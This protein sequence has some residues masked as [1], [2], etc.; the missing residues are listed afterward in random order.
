MPNDPR[1]ENAQQEGSSRSTVEPSQSQG[2]CLPSTAFGRI[3]VTLVPSEEFFI[4]RKD[5]CI[6][7]LL[8]LQG[9]LGVF[10]FFRGN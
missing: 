7:P 3:S 1:K 6:K 9:N 5:V 10:A 2:S 8:V 4:Y